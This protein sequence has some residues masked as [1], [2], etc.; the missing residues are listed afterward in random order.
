MLFAIIVYWLVFGFILTGAVFLNCP[1]SHPTPADLFG[2]IVMFILMVL[3]WPVTACFW[4]DMSEGLIPE[5]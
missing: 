4:V 1:L 3:F 2:D 5:L